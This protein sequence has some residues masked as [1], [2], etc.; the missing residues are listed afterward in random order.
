MTRR[1]CRSVA[2]KLLFSSLDNKENNYNLT[3]NEIVVDE[4]ISQS[5]MEFINQLYNTVIENETEIISSISL[6]LQGYEWKRV[7]K[8]DKCLLMLAIC[9]M[10]YIK[11]TPQKVII[12]ETIELAK[13]YSTEKSPKFINGILAQ[14]VGD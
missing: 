1:E 8:V 3:L 14:F 10:N 7:Y 11:Q 2:L 9:E 13:E 12:N 4:S 6:K 5:D